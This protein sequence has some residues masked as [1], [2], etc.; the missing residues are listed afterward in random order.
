[1]LNNASLRSLALRLTGDKAD[2]LIQEVALVL[3]EKTD[4][5]L[6][7]ISEYFNFWAVRTM[8]NMAAPRAKMAKYEERMASQYF[9]VADSPYDPT[10]DEMVR[11]ANNELNRMH[12]YRKKMFEEYIKVGSMRELSRQTE[13]PLNTISGTIREVREELKQCLKRL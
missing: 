5:E 1:M 9:E 7:R 13:I 11:K 12:W 3:C 6:E 10:E 8:M 4:D 2:D